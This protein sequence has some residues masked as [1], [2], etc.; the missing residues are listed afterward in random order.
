[1]RFVCLNPKCKRQFVYSAKNIL[2][3]T[4]EQYLDLR[5]EK[6]T[7]ASTHLPKVT[8]K[9]TL[10]TQVCPYCQSKDFEESVEPEKVEEQP[11]EDM[12]QVPF[13][14]VKEYITK[15]YVEL[16]RKDHVYAK[17]LVMVKLQTEEAKQ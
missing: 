3:E 17:G 10:E 1:M 16:D 6:S 2:E 7:D 15:G 12:L 5:F 9:T 11:L 4:P 8:I 14:Q 13:E